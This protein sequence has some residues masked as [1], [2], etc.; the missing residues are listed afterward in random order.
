MPERLERELGVPVVPTVHQTGSEAALDGRLL[1]TWVR[2]APSDL[3]VVNDDPHIRYAV[4]GVESSYMSDRYMVLA[5][6]VGPEV[7]R[8]TIDVPGRDEAEA[9]MNH[10]WI[11]IWWPGTIDDDARLTAYDAQGRRLAQVPVTYE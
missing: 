2:F 8:V 6:R 1:L 3:R 4:N 11:S 5:G 9:S 7:D 10:G